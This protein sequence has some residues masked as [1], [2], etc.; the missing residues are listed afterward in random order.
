MNTTKG[1]L[2]QTEK[3]MESTLEAFHNPIS[4]KK[5]SISHGRRT[6]II[7]K[8]NDN[9]HITIILEELLDGNLKLKTAFPSCDLSGINI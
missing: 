5:T 1:K 4:S 8:S 2:E 3:I 9:L 6:K 7:G